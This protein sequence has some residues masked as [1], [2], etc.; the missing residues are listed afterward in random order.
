MSETR[1]A[2]VVKASD[3]KPSEMVQGKLGASSQRLGVAAGGWSLGCTLVELAVGNQAFPNHFHSAME[4]SIY[5]LE[6]EGTLRIGKEEM[7]IAAGDY[8]AFPPGPDFSHSITNTGKNKLR[9]LCMSA[10]AS[11]ITV[12]VVG[13]PDSKRIAFAAGVQ[14]GKVAW[15]DG[16]WV[17]KLIKEDTPQVGYFDDEPMAQK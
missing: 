9:Y 8:A 7:K 13:Y 17:M 15:R 6:G 10:P 11:P 4:E 16:A 3:V 14:P 12:D 5:V 2:K 1:T